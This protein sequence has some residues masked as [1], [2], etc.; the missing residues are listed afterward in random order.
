LFARA[1]LQSGSCPTQTETRAQ[2]GGT[3]FAGDAGCSDS[4]PGTAVACLRALS[5]AQLLNAQSNFGFTPILVRG[6][7]TLPS[8]PRTAIR[9]G[10]FARVPV[11][12][13]GTLDEAR[14]FTSGY[15]G[16]TRADYENWVTDVFGANADAVIARY[17]WPR[18]A[19]QVTPAYLT[20][21][22]MTDAGII[23][24]ERPPIEA[25][26]GGCST[27]AL[28]RDIARYSRTYAYEWAPQSG[29]GIVQ[30]AGYADGAGHGSELAYL[31]P[32]FEQ[33]GVRLSSL[34]GPPERQLSDQI[35]Q[36]WGAFVR[37]GAPGGAGQPS[38]RPYTANSAVVLSLRTNRQ[39]TL[40]R[41]ATIDTEHRC[42]FWNTL[43][44]R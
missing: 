40:V 9:D 42:S 36:Y 12:I 30:S 20:G 34:F 27:Q 24:P 35:V 16:W 11:L 28:T 22:V 21:A 7:R 25:G 39:S 13:G 44:G 17:R 33:N 31:W 38:W 4:N 6:T 8:D 19:N 15:V 29:P 2:A 23:G 37:T 3:Q 10:D 5:P 43:A 18:G 26:V 1:T 14:A 32:N 41:S